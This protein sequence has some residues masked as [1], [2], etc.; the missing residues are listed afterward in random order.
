MTKV[1]VA[2]LIMVLAVTTGCETERSTGRAPA[3]VPS[4]TP[5]ATPSS[6]PTTRPNTLNPVRPRS[7]VP[8]L[9]AG[10]SHAPL[11]QGVPIKPG[12]DPQSVIDLH[13]DGTTFCFTGGRHRIE[14]TIEPPAGTTLA[15][16]QRAELTG[17]VDLTGWTEAGGHWVLHGALP[18]PY[19]PVGQCEDDKANLC[20]LREQVFVGDQHLRRV[21]SAGEVEAG[22]F[23]ADYRSNTIHLGSDPA[24]QHVEMSST[25][26]AIGGG[27]ENVTVRGL[28]VERFASPSQAAAIEAGPRWRVEYNDIRWNHAV[29]LKLAQADDARAAH[30]L[31]V[32]NG[33]LGVSQWRSQ[34]A[35]ITGN[36][37]ARNNTDGFWIADWESGGIKSTWS[38]GRTENNYVHDNLGVGIWSDIDENHKTIS[39]NRITANA[40][41]GIR[42]EI[43]YNGTITGNTIV[44][45]GFGIGRTGA[46]GGKTLFDTAGINVNTSSVVR[47][48][49]NT[50]SGN[51]NSISVQSRQR[52][53]GEIGEW[54]LR[55]VIVAANDVTMNSGTASIG[56]VLEDEAPIPAGGVQFTGNRY[57][58]DHAGAARF[59]WMNQVMSS[60]GWRQAGNDRNGSYD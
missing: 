54:L 4:G 41:C 6:K 25:E 55:D 32:D 53:S 49:G 20:H 59:T 14:R 16:S 40:A 5:S 29:G 17:S 35:V 21:G 15:S 51:Q 2:A 36:E 9:P 7:T 43:S 60:D 18:P 10:P 23:Y 26:A 3:P 22:T 48:E 31:I 12:Q 52:G 37:I 57:H 24:G 34:G 30:N 19:G 28:T 50:V 8:V 13:P 27:A 42:Y 56:T 46:G 1:P 45:N 11:C 44:G 58:L 33:Q 47:V 38:S 39:N